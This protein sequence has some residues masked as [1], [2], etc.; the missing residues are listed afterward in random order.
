MSPKGGPTNLINE[1]RTGQEDRIYSRDEEE[2]TV[3][4]AP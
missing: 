3:E 1:A 2:R 4:E